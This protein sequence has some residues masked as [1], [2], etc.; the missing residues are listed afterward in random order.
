MTNKSGQTIEY[1]ENE[2]EIKRIFHYFGTLF[3]KANTATFLEGDSTTSRHFSMRN[4]PVI[5][6]ST[7]LQITAYIMPPI[8]SFRSFQVKRKLKFD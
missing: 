5:I 1:L 3:I 2:D 6:S 8:L 7:P 4:F